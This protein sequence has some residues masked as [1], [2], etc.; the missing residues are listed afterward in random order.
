MTS[1]ALT[2]GATLAVSVDGAAWQTITFRAADFEDIGAATAT[3][4]AAV[5]TRSGAVAAEVDEH[6]ALALLSPSAGGHTSVEIDAGRSTAAAPLG[7]S[8]TSTRAAGSGLHAARLVSPAAAPF[9]L[10]PSAEMTVV[11]DGHRRRIAFDKGISAGKATAA[12]V[13][14]V[15]NVRVRRLARATSDDRVMLTSP[16]IGS[17][18]RLA[19]LPGRT[20]QGKTD[21]AAIFGFT[22]AAAIDEPYP[23]LPARLHCGGPRAGV[24]AINLTAGAIELLL[25]AG[26]TVV[27]AGGSVP[28]APGD[29]GHSPL[30]RLI[31]RGAVRLVPESDV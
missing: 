26:P 22:G 21:A 29:A 6:G 19:V 8:G 13:E 1:Y 20:D 11:V 5:L 7:L 23:T 4:L 9:P 27:P 10:Q 3:E 17:G 31:E 24:R 2:D 14:Q 18:S 15:I 30:Q 16:T 28:L 25:P 12:E